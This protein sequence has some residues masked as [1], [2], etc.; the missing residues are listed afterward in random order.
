MSG[1]IRIQI[2]PFFE[3]ASEPDENISGS[4]L[5]LIFNLITFLKSTNLWRTATVVPEWMNEV[6]DSDEDTDF[7]GDSDDESESSDDDDDD[8][9]VEMAATLPSV[10][11]EEDP[12]EP[13]PEAVRKKPEPA[14]LGL[15]DEKEETEQVTL[16]HDRTKYNIFDGGFYPVPVEFLFATLSCQSF[17]PLS[18]SGIHRFAE[19]TICKE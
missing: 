13:M 4:G 11:A 18:N 6:E 2:S 3:T 5:R 19:K 15:D 10:P 8:G 9:D 12:D 1:A 17:Y 16:F 14:F 7:M